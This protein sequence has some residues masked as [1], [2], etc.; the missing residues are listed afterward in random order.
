METV[1]VPAVAERLVSALSAFVLCARAL[2]RQTGGAASDL[3]V[4]GTPSDSFEALHGQLCGQ[5]PFLV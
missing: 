4:S 2:A 5:L 1:R 3:D